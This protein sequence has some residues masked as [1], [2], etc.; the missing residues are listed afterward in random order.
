[1]R[2]IKRLISIV[3]QILDTIE[4]AKNQPRVREIK[5]LLNEVLSLLED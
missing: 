3:F 2:E 1:M 5:G 4:N